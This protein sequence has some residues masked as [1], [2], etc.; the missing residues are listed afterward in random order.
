[1]G[2]VSK[3]EAPG[4]QAS[5]IV[6]KVLPHTLTQQR[7]PC[8][9]S[10]AA[11]VRRLSSGRRVLTQQRPQS[12]DSAA[13]HQAG[14]HIQLGGSRRTGTKPHT[15][16][17][18]AAI[19]A[20]ALPPDP[21]AKTDDDS[22]AAG[23]AVVGLGSGS[24]IRRVCRPGHSCRG[25]CRPCRRA[26]SRSHC[27]RWRWP[28]ATPHER[29]QVAHKRARDVEVHEAVSAAAQRPH[30]RHTRLRHVQMLERAEAR[31]LRQVRQLGVAGA[32]VTQRAS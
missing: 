9:D 2:K 7:P 18:A 4:R 31:Q 24:L 14:R 22:V 12:V 8:A 32:Q 3:Q 10:A 11:A 16:D 19:S 17:L 25:A 1:M 28:G 6:L 13:A 30:V 5:C 29:R 26:R 27:L 23:V 15:C 20:A 21:A